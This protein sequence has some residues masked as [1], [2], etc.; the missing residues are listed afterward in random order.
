M[1]AE[2]KEARVRR[3]DARSGTWELLFCAMIELNLANVIEINGEM[4]EI[5][6]NVLVHRVNA[7]KKS[8]GGM[9]YNA[10]S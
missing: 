1:P 7:P 5:I 8:L 2:A 6:F 9:E 4:A 3:T 10:G